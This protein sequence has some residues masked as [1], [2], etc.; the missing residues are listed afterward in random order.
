MRRDWRYSAGNY[1]E[2]NRKIARKWKVRAGKDK[3][4]K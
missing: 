1:G 4:G 3:K 2:E